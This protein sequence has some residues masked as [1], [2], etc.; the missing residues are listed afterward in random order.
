MAPIHYFR[1]WKIKYPIIDKLKDDLA[2]SE[3]Y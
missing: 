3:N 1:Y 2:A